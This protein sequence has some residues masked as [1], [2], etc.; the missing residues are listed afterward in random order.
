M[1]ELVVAWPTIVGIDQLVLPDGTNANLQAAA[2]LVEEQVRPKDDPRHYASTVGNHLDVFPAAFRTDLDTLWTAVSGALR[3]YLSGGFGLDTPY[4]FV[5]SLS[6]L[7]ARAGNRVS[8]H[9]HPER[10]LFAAYYPHIDPPDKD[11]TALNG[12]ELRLLDS[13]GWARK[14]LNRNPSMF[15]AE[16][17]SLR[18]KPGMLFIGPGYALHETN[19]FSGPGMRVTYSFFISLHMARDFGVFGQSKET[20]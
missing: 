14:W 9:T 13:R 15:D 11:R 4:P 16:C 17:L 6:I 8:A 18:P 10:D 2:L 5:W 1:P 19:P 3:Q 7:V 12:G 20:P